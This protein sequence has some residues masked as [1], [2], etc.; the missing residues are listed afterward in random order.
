MENSLRDDGNIN[1][2]FEE[3]K[4]EEENRKS[5]TMCTLIYL[6]F[7]VTNLFANIDHGVMP[8]ATVEMRRDLGIDSGM[9]G[10]L[11]GLVYLGLVAGKLALLCR[12]H[13]C[14]AS[15]QLLQRENSAVLLHL[16]QFCLLDALLLVRN[17]LGPLL[18]AFSGRLLPGIF[19]L[20]LGLLLHLRARLGRQVCRG[21]LE[22]A[23]AHFPYAR[24]AARYNHRLCHYS[25]LHHL[26]HSKLP[27]T[28]QW[29]FTFFIQSLAHLPLA[30]LTL[31]IPGSYLHQ[32]VGN[33]RPGK[34]Q[35]K[36]HNGI[37]STVLE[38]LNI[39]N[40]S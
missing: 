35:V 38:S 27:L 14:D 21:A 29:K 24:D 17:C 15:V 7:F 39:Q 31:L 33:H 30:L 5:M 28:S 4:R 2:T 26:L 23:P 20:T 32:N 40:L 18:I 12:I 37:G 25:P 8:A 36:R 22:D 10:L 6:L 3:I 1:E 13:R 11:G 16:A 19:N 9:I 34:I